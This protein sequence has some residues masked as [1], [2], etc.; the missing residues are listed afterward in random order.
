MAGAFTSCS[1]QGAELPGKL[2]GVSQFLQPLAPDSA[3][4][5]WALHALPH[6]RASLH[7]WLTG[8]NGSLHSGSRKLEPF[9][10]SRGWDPGAVAQAESPQ[11]WMEK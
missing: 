2:F 9:P 4:S 6:R 7:R 10:S 1:E 3:L 8:R 5:L 11:P